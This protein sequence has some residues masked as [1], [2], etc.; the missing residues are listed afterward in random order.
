MTRTTLIASVTLA[1]TATAFGTAFWAGSSFLRSLPVEAA[2][3]AGA[4]TEAL[5]QN[6]PSLEPYPTATASIPLIAA[7]RYAL[8]D[9]ESGKLVAQQDAFVE[10]PIA[11]TTKLMTAHL[12]S[13][14]G[15]LGDILTVSAQAAGQDGSVAHL[16]EGEQLSLKDTLY[17]M[18]LV[19]GNDAAHALAEYTGGLLL[20]TPSA[21]PEQKT[22][23]FVDEMNSEA[24]RLKMSGTHYVDPAGF[25]DEGHS[26]AADLAKIASIDLT[27]AAIQPIMDTATYSVTDQRGWYHQD[28]R[29]SDR[30]IADAPLVGTIGG[31]T[32]FTLGA[33]HCLVSAAKRDGHTLVAIILNTDLGD[34]DASSREARKLLEYGFRSV[35]WQ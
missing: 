9:V 29:N 15:H 19:S 18:L 3:V 10:A 4:S 13:T 27:D 24:G 2:A 35:S 31:K 21:S 5:G 23:R 17:C 11:S 20:H 8:L 28:L 33:G 7:S 22:A 30:L 1:I 32:G 25:M 14:V 26:T 34:V 6:L 12:V 16:V